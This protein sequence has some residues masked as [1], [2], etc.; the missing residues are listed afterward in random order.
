MMGWIGRLFGAAAP[1]G[2]ADDY[3]YMPR[4]FLPATGVPVTVDRALKV[5]AVYASLQVLANPIGSLPLVI[6]R[7]RADGSKERVDSHPLFAVLHDQANAEA[8]AYEFRGQMQWDLA[9]HRN[10]YAEIIPGPRGA[11][12]QLVRLDPL[13]L[14]SYRREDGSVWYE[15]RSRAPSRHLSAEEVWHLK[16]LPLAADGLCGVSTLT[17]AQ[18]TIAHAIAVQDY[19]AR[20]FKND[21]SSGGILEHPGSF[22]TEEDRKAFL[23][24][25]RRARTGANQH[26][27]AL[28]E[29]GIKY[30]RAPT[31]NNEHAQFLQTRNAIAVEVAQIWRVP[32]HKIGILDRATFSN[33]EQQALEF[34]T[35]TLL[36]WIVLWEQAIK[37]DLILAPG[38]F[39]EF[40][41]AGLLRGDLKTRYEAYAVARNW[42][43]LSVND[44]RR[45]ENMNPIEDG[46]EY[47]R[48]LNM[49]TPGSEAGAGGQPAPQEGNN[50]RR[51]PRAQLEV[52]DG[53]G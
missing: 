43:W 39:A 44:I 20:F 5:P 45:L 33:I 4:G 35:D 2:P 29:F 31:L 30:N 16:A 11:V 36:P 26:R 51:E 52:I 34:V 18:E 25:W 48:P 38:Y 12:D 17:T 15:D 49:T 14:R 47:L 53:R 9:L 13:K 21:G 46:D 50:R 24:S 41:V 32:P 3:W 27:D 28:A 7:K 8:T 19:G 42:G 10:A 22:R 6:F 37:R 23:A 40:N 1:P